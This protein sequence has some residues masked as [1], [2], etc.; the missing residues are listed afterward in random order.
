MTNTEIPK[1]EAV[2]SIVAF[3]IADAMARGFVRLKTAQ[4]I[5]HAAKTWKA[6]IRAPIRKQYADAWPH[7]PAAMMTENAN[8]LLARTQP[9]KD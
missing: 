1:M 4:V 8:D 3:Q 6:C 5:E 7:L 9:P 2:A